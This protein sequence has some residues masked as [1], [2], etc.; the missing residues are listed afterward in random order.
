PFMD[1]LTMNQS[2]PFT[3]KARRVS[4]ACDECRKRKTKCIGQGQHC[5]A[6]MAKKVA[7]TF[8]FP[9]CKRGPKP[10]LQPSYF[11]L[12]A[13]SS[14]PTSPHEPTFNIDPTLQHL[15]RLFFQGEL[16]WMS[17][18]TLHLL[19]LYFRHIHPLTNSLV[20]PIHFLL[21][22]TQPKVTPS[23]QLL[24]YSML[25]LTLRSIPNL[26]NFH[27][28]LPT[29]ELSAG[30]EDPEITDINH[31]LSQIL[32]RQSHTINLPF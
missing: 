32:L 18:A 26:R 14:N 23:F 20:D 4:R 17:Y 6:C 21:G 29:F 5:Q 31:Q 2:R 19:H 30:T 11:S 16:G 27:L 8:Q 10:K 15:D 9:T 13:S 24:L 28:Q 25:D 1:H 3:M 22:M 7:C 12:P